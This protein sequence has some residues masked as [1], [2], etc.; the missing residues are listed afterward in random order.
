MEAKKV[1]EGCAEFP[2]TT[3]GMR[4]QVMMMQNKPRKTM[5]VTRN[6]WPAV[7]PCIRSSGIDMKS[8]LSSKAMLKEPCKKCCA[9]ECVIW[10]GLGSICQ[11]RWNGWHSVKV[12]T[13]TVSY[14]AARRIQQHRMAIRAQCN[15]CRRFE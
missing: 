7:L 9:Y 14:V 10:P 4:T 13:I 1:R 8:M 12:T 3:R 5:T 11:Y 2:W 15:E 6:F